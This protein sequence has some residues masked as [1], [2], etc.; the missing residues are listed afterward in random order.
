VKDFLHRQPHGLI[1]PVDGRGVLG[2]SVGSERLSRGQ[3]GAH[4]FIARNEQC[5][6]NAQAIEHRLVSSCFPNMPNHLFSSELFQVVGGMTGAILRFTLL[7]HSADLLGELR[8]GK[9]TGKRRQ[10]QD[11]FY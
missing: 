7:P 3:D 6:H 1:V 4:D 11:R 8:C 2:S 10:R 5:G 9:A